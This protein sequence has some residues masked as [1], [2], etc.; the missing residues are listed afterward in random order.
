MSSDTRKASRLLLGFALA[1]IFTALPFAAVAL[2]ALPRTATLAVVAL[3]AIIQVLVHLRYFLRLG[4]MTARGQIIAVTGF[5]AVLIAIM[6]GGSLWIMFD[7][8]HRMMPVEMPDG[9]P[10]P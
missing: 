8:H 9:P 4:S 6:M 2:N 3:T 5:V 10:A 1:A 7:L